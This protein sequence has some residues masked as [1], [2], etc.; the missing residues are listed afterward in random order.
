MQNDLDA[1]AKMQVKP[2]IA[3]RTNPD[4]PITRKALKKSKNGR[5][6]SASKMGIA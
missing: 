6:K 5:K 3:V 2:K 4:F 1:Y